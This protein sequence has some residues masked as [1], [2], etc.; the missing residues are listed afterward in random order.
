MVTFANNCFRT[1]GQSECHVS[2][3]GNDS[4]DCSSFENPC[5]SL[6]QCLINCQSECTIV[7]ELVLEPSNNPGAASDT[8]CGENCLV[9]QDFVNIEIQHVSSQESTDA[10]RIVAIILLALIL[11]FGFFAIFIWLSVLSARENNIM[12][13]ELEYIE[14]PDVNQLPL[15]HLIRL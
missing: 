7:S 5:G 12:H 14:I 9:Q 3:L 1:R 10:Q 13:I 4:A 6:S 8:N 11:V 15:Q 2:S